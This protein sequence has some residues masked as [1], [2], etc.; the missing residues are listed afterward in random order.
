[1]SKSVPQRDAVG[2][3]VQGNPAMYD[4]DRY[5]SRQPFV[6]W[7]FPHSK[8]LASIGMPVFIK[9]SGKGGGLVA[10]GRVAELPAPPEEVR[11]QH[12]RGEDLWIEGGEKAEPLCGIELLEARLTESEGMVPTAKLQAIPELDSRPLSKAPRA[13]VFRLSREHL[14]G[15]MREWGTVLDWQ[16]IDRT[17]AATE[18]ERRLRTHYTIERRSWIVAE[19]KRRFREE[20]GRLFCEVC[21][22]DYE[23]K[24]GELWDER[25]IE[26]H[27]V[28]P[29]A[30]LDEPTVTELADLI[31]VCATCHRLVHRT[32]DVEENLS[33]LAALFDERA[34]G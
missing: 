16:V 17:P 19:K 7:R 1:M 21:Q 6:Y 24:Y 9:R 14:A 3:V 20:H 29:L 15:V 12:L 28:R 25:A 18:G 32:D 5:L 13:T 4:I 26:A 2:F 33:R 22:T 10:L 27:H 23:A 8:E 34:A 30:T 11:W 31:L